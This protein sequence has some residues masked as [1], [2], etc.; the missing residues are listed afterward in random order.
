M[1]NLLVNLL[2]AGALGLAACVSRSQ[3]TSQLVA[4]DGS[5]SRKLAL[6]VAVGHYYQLGA[7]QGQKP[8]PMLH[9][10]PETEEYRQT[11]VRDYGFR[12]EDVLVLLDEKA[13][14]ASIRRAFQD[15]LVAKARPGD[16]V[17]FHFSGHGQQL[18]DQLG[19]L[20]DEEDG[21]D[22][23]LVPYDALDQSVAEG[24]RKNIRDDEV[25]VWLESLVKKMTKVGQVHGHI[26]VT[27]DSCFSGSATRGSLVAR[28]RAW[29]E[30]MDGQRPAH[31]AFAHEGRVGMMRAEQLADRN[32]VVVSASRSDQS[33]WEKN[34]R[35]VFTRH[36]LKLLGTASSA[37]LPSYRA[38][39]D[40]LAIDIA[41]EGVDQSPQVEGAADLRLF[42]GL[43]QPLS[44]PRDAVRVYVDGKGALRLQAGE[45]HDVTVGSRYALYELGAAQLDSAT[46]LADAVVTE[47]GPFTAAL[48]TKRMLGARNGALAVETAHAFPLLPLRVRL[49]GLT[50]D[51]FDESGSARN[52]RPIA[53]SAEDGSSP[54]IELRYQPGTKQIEVYRPTTSQRVLAVEASDSGRSTIKEWLRAEWRRRHFSQLRNENEAARVELELIPVEADI[55]EQTR[56]VRGTPMPLSS[57]PPGPH[58]GIPKGKSFLLRL[59]NRSSKPRYAALLAISPDGDID[60]LYP[61]EVGGNRIPAGEIIEPPLPT[62]LI[63]QPGERVVLKV[64]A[65]DVF[66][67]FTGVSTERFRNRTRGDVPVVRATELYRPLQELLEDIGEGTRGEARNLQPSTWGTSDGSIEITEALPILTSRPPEQ[68]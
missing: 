31:R 40:R 11:L 23:S 56:R 29:D 33:A 48:E 35:G 17:L 57:P 25:G 45:L 15:H 5:S 34:A 18:P 44:R 2:L 64:I 13:T 36:W 21:L 20:A 8:W 9:V 52:N 6:L 3:S 59:R 49:S 32:I 43:A 28:G 58:V 66:V 16:V 24:V 27:L 65:T 61:T 26:L 50:W 10:G 54:D 55:D 4:G 51:A 38:A 39:L 22:E 62:K 68:P 63:G 7:P 19:P 1:Q 30:S 42:S 67:D 47:A 41:A 46:K 53:K 60:R 12:P 37:A 14:A